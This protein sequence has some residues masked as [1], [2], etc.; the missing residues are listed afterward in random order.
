MLAVFVILRILTSIVWPKEDE[1]ST[2]PEAM[3]M[4]VRVR[5]AVVM[6]TTSTF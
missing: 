5:G 3:G 1:S 6:S 4:V 2:M